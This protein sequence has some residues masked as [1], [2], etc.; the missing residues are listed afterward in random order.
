MFIQLFSDSRGKGACNETG[1]SLEGARGNFEWVKIVNRFTLH[2][3]DASHHQ[4][5]Y[6]IFLV[7][8]PVQK[9]QNATVTGWWGRSK[10]IT[11]SKK[12]VPLDMFIKKDWGQPRVGE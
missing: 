9:A 6:H 1:T 10:H 4:D 7:G 2:H 11:F 3:K 5:Y 12:H 8:N